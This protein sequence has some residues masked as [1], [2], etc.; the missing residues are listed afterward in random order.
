MK[1]LFDVNTMIRR[2]NICRIYHILSN[3][4]VNIVTLGDKKEKYQS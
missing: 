3:A 2:S 4:K 1:I